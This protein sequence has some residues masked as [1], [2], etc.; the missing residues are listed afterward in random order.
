MRVGELPRHGR[1]EFH[2][3]GRAA[4]TASISR[5]IVIQLYVY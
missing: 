1:G 5:L 4:R 3:S 2:I